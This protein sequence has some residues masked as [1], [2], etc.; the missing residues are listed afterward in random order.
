MQKSATTRKPWALQS[1]QKV[2]YILLTVLLFIGKVWLIS[3]PHL[4]LFYLLAAR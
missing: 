2:I 3:F 4:Q 1:V